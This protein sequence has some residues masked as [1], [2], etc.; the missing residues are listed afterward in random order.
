MKF[1]I[2][3]NEKDGFFEL[4]DEYKDFIKSV[5]FAPPKEFIST[6]RT[7]R[8]EWDYVW[9]VYILNKKCK[10]LWIEPI[11]L[12]NSMFLWKE[13]FDNQHLSKLFKFIESVD[14]IS[15]V[16]LKVTNML[17][18]KFL[19]KKFPNKKIYSSVN[20]RVK[21]LEHA[22]YIKDLWLDVI[23]IDRDI[24][25]NIELIKQIK[26]KTGL[27]LQLMLNE[28]CFRNC[29]FRHE[30]FQAVAWWYE[31]LHWVDFEELTCYP[32]L[33][34]NNRRL[35]RIPFV[36]PE[37]LQYYKGYINHFKLVTRDSPTEQIKFLLE[38]YTKQNYDWNLIN[39]FDREV[40]THWWDL[41]VDNKK[42]D[43]L[44]FFEKIQHCPW[45]CYSCNICEVFFRN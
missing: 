22:I 39:I 15:D 30:H 41:Y 37:D 43:R 14:E 3:Y 38:I 25:R 42:L 7:P 35:F 34:K 11:M 36:R 13:T 32:M 26:G 44:N 6:W 2:W 1:S 17:F 27:E 21:T 18:Y 4:L 31:T 16:S 29:P 9:D 19:R 33:R 8:Q 40:I 12:L 5:Y 10:E 23:T 45:D 20:C 28:N 24:N